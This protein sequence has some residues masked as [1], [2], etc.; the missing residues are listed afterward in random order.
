MGK[1]VKIKGLDSLIKTLSNTEVLAK[2]AINK[3]GGIEMT[4]PNCKRKIRVPFSGTTCTC[5]QKIQVN[6]KN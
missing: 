2:S 4:C 5:G 1:N 3:N 6:M